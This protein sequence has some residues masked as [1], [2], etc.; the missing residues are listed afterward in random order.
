M[1]PSQR[2]AARV[3][4]LQRQLSPAATVNMLLAKMKPSQLKTTTLR[5][6]AMKKNFRSAY[7]SATWKCYN[8]E[9]THPRC[10]PPLFRRWIKKKCPFRTDCP[11]KFQLNRKAKRWPISAGILAPPSVLWIARRYSRESNPHS[12]MILVLLA[13]SVIEEEVCRTNQ[14][15]CQRTC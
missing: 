13:K 10:R 7:P 12:Q 9:S 6:N 5:K 14:E 2:A 3:K 11:T 1:P 8:S 15:T 4:V